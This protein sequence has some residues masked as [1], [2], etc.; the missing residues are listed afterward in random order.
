[1]TEVHLRNPQRRNGC[2]PGIFDR[3]NKHGFS[4][5]RSSASQSLA[6]GADFASRDSELQL[7][8]AL[9]FLGA[10]NHNSCTVE[11]LQLQCYLHI[12]ARL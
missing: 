7:W 9:Q 4:L 6:Y 11:H 10:N 5:I 2:D 12:S 1:M 8:S 3:H